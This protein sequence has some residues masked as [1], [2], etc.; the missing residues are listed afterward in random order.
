MGI[1]ITILYNFIDEHFVLIR[2]NLFVG[3]KILRPINVYILNSL[4]INIS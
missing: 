1:G 4:I 3:I 2:R